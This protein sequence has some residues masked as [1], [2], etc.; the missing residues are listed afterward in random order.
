MQI[1]AQLKKTNFDQNVITSSRYR[2][3]QQLDFVDVRIFASRE[4]VCDVN[5]NPQSPR[6]FLM[7]DGKMIWRKDVVACK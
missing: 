4:G 1:W 3:R 7:R 5:V 2:P 6:H